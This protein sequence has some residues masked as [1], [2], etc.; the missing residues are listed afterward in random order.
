[1]RRGQVTSLLGLE[2]HEH[3]Y[4]ISALG[5]ALEQATLGERATAGI[6]RARTRKP[7]D[8]IAPGYA[9]LA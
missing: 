2:A 8:T 4:S 1:M 3:V 6:V 7:L 9:A 5:H